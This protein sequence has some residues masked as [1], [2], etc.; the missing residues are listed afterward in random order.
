MNSRH[1]VPKDFTLE[2]SVAVFA[3]K[4]P[5]IH[6]SET[7]W[8]MQS[9]SRCRLRPLRRWHLLT[10]V[11][12]I[13]F[14]SADSTYSAPQELSTPVVGTELETIQNTTSDT[15]TLAVVEVVAPNLPFYR[16]L[17][18]QTP[19]LMLE[20]LQDLVSYN[21]TTAT[22]PSN[23]GPWQR[24]HVFSSMMALQP[25]AT[26]I[27]LFAYFRADAEI[28]VRLNTN[29][30]YQGALMIT[31]NPYYRPAS[32]STAPVDTSYQARSWLKP[33]LLSAS[34]QETVV[35][36]LP[37]TMAQR[38]LA[39]SSL[40]TDHDEPWT[41]FFDV[42]AQLRTSSPAAPTTIVVKVQC[43]W[44]NPDLILPLQTDAEPQS[45]RATRA[46]PSRLARKKGTQVVISTGTSTKSP[47]E[48]AEAPPAPTTTAVGSTIVKSIHAGVDSIASLASALQPLLPYAGMM[49]GFLDKP[50]APLDF[51]RIVDSGGINTSTADTAD[52]SL[53]LTL[54]KT[55]YLAI[56]HD[57]IPD[58]RPWTA[59]DVATTP[60]LYALWPFYTGNTSVSIPYMQQGTP[61]CAMASQHAL[62]RGSLRLQF[63]FYC[64]MFVSARFLITITPTTAATTLSNNVSRL[65]DVKGDTVVNMTFPFIY[66]VDFM[67]KDSSFEIIQ[68][69]NI[70]V[71]VYNQIVT[72]DASS[73][74][75]IDMV[76]FGAGGPD[77]QFSYPTPG[78]FRYPPNPTTRYDAERQSEI[79]SEFRG[80]F[81]PFVTGSSYMTDHHVNTSETTVFITD[82]LKRYTWC[83]PIQVPGKDA[84]QLPV[85]FSPVEDTIQYFLANMFVFHKGGLRYKNFSFAPVV[86]DALF[87]TQPTGV[88]PPGDP[89][90]ANGEAWF[91]SISDAQSNDA[92]VPYV[93]QYP[94]IQYINLDHVPAMYGVMY[95]IN[96][97]ETPGT[98]QTTVTAYRDDVQLGYLYP[99][100]PVVVP[101]GARRDSTP[102]PPEVKEFGLMFPDAPAKKQ[103]S[104]FSMFR[105]W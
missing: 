53:P 31:G 48:Q 55:S 100:P 99:P 74:P 46:K 3:A 101:L 11:F 32:A 40:T 63:R 22:V 94:F 62:W 58:G 77:S 50:E 1:T 93:S 42:I 90:F 18:D 41:V 15:G 68:P 75:I 97:T 66:P 47:V 67:V 33:M 8:K 7:K 79:V 82:I 28:H 5:R 73:T 52:I 95:G 85:T 14:P 89:W 23:T 12:T 96:E 49:L 10:V 70:Y 37:W 64:T 78:S 2:A 54:Y 4:G 24:L 87:T 16:P 51:T 103:P 39:P 104:R 6:A 43:R 26:L 21:W 27:P 71:S 76:V 98:Y 81:P 60:A 86:G 56:D 30:F 59:L 20:R 57:G 44:L 36:K 65:V 61:F 25:A 17:A 45:E 29:Q 38:M 88:A 91:P 19:R 84:F 105:K 72:N 9:T 92:T 35:L 83:N 102:T 80:D 13:L 69:Y 34:L